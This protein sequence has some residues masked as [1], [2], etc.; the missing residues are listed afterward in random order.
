MYVATGGP[1]WVNHLW[2]LFC[3]FGFIGVSATFFLPVAPLGAE[4]PP[5]VRQQ[6]IG[7]DG[8]NTGH[9]HH[10]MALESNSTSENRQIRRS[11]SDLHRYFHWPHAA[12]HGGALSLEYRNGW[13]R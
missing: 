5:D 1:T 7:A 13:I 3:V 2:V 9:V 8:E 4:D 11:L 12:S 6:V 10:G